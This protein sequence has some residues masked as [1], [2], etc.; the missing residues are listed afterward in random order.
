MGTVIGFVLGVAFF[1]AFAWV[2]RRLLGVS[3]LSA[4]KTIISAA[5]GVFIGITIERLLEVRG[6]FDRD[7]A[8]VAGLVLGL[9]FTMVM[10]LL[11][12]ATSGGAPRSR[13]TGITRPDLAAQQAVDRG[14]R[15][16]EL[17][18]IASRHGLSKGFGLAT[19]ATMTP[20]EAAA[21]GAD[22]RV[23][24]EEAGPVFVKLGQLLAT[25]PDLIPQETADE[26]AQLHQDVEP[27]P[28]DGIEPAI[29]ASLG[30]TIDE[31]FAEFDWSPIGAASIGQVYRA[32]L[33]SG[34]AVVVKARR[35]DIEAVVDRDL[36]LALQVAQLAEERSEQAQKLGI[37]DVADQ[38]ASQLREEMDYTIE[39][40]N[41]VEA[42]QSLDPHGSIGIPRVFTEYTGEALLVQE[43]V[44]GETLGR[45]GV[46]GG[47][48]G[49]RLADD[50][51]AFEV[52]AMLTG[53]R[54][55]ADPHP[56][57]VI[58]CPDGS[59]ALIDFG[60]AGRLDTFER[61]AVTDILTALA[62]N[63]PSLLREAAL[64]VGMEGADIDPARLDRAFARLM[65]DH[66]GPGAEP[67]AELLKDFLGIANDFGL[68]MPTS[69]T[70]MLRALATLQGSLEVLSP[71][72]PIIDAAQGVAVGQLEA[73][74][75]PENLMEEVKR[76]TIR[77]APLLRRAPVQ[78]DRIAGQIEQG[79]ASVRVS[80][81]SNEDDVRVVSRLVNRFVLAF[82]GA[83]LGIVSAML[84]QLEEGPQ[85]SENVGL[86]DLLAFV[87]LFS[88]AILIMRVVLEVL[89]ER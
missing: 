89:R 69:V 46:V 1:L 37:A 8:V 72:Y 62:V 78:L 75:T 31:V 73:E 64:R 80:L 56:G 71:G 9:I 84:F 24:L 45:H 77:L 85:L 35:P 20:S 57:N 13:R 34:E 22:L 63:D 6:G 65:A 70:E 50:L 51:F 28:R 15:S 16:V 18:R 27:A 74:L 40:R 61:A 47:D 83:A 36:D 52:G 81:F 76:E 23:A 66:L 43:L 17:T 25:R 82:V 33:T 5:V 4:T 14:R 58:L 32:R 3:R 11:F 19:G 59:L 53:G 2:A 39:A 12:E 88:G 21:Y 49:R 54:F 79:K 38:F 55:H 29:E 30:T 60:S 26:L 86:F 41:T 67:T 42:A 7:L 48:Q 44:D 10:I 68:R 87:G